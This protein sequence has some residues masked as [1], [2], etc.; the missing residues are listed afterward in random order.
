MGTRGY[1]KTSRSNRFDSGWLTCSTCGTGQ[2]RERT[3]STVAN[4]AESRA[5]YCTEHGEGSR[6]ADRAGLERVLGEFVAS[7]RKKLVLTGITDERT[8]SDMPA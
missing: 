3:G 6:A 4:G 5:A 8:C 2:G 7:Q 1:L